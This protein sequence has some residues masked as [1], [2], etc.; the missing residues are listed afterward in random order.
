VA[1]AEVERRFGLC[2][3]R[4]QGYERSVK[5]VL[6]AHRG[7]VPLDPAA[8]AAAARVGQFDPQTLGVLVGQMTGSFLG[9]AEARL[10]GDAPE[11]LLGMSWHFRIGLSDQDLAQVEA[12]LR[13]V[14]AL[15][16]RLV[17]HFTE[18][19]DLFTV[20]GCARASAALD[21]AG[22][23]IDRARADLRVWA[24]DLD[25]ARS[26]LAEALS[27]PDFVASLTGGRPLR[28]MTAIVQALRA[29]EPALAH[30]GWAPLRAA[31]AWIAARHPGE[32]PGGYGCRSWLHLV[33]ESRLFDLRVQ[34]GD[35]ARTHWYRSKAG[36]V[37]E[38]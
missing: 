23:R 2:V 9:S 10:Q 13:D 4:L 17:H 36:V 25:R 29:A 32:E 26:T 34:Q 14:V 38:P 8:R 1:Q 35:E 24:D 7:F 19:H 3:L 18:D 37:A 27:C 16:N 28:P 22:A 6:A 12:D 11:P 33:Q 15:R 5:A 31:V 30:E 21:E 20:E